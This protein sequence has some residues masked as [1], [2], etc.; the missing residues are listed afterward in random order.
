MEWIH[1]PVDI[2]AELYDVDDVT[3]YWIILLAGLILGLL[4]SP[5]ENRG[6]MIFYTVLFRPRT[7]YD[8]ELIHE[9]DHKLLNACSY[10]GISK[11]KYINVSR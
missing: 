4:A 9:L 1:F 5:A 8:C 7:N 2:C 3:R 11:Q 6:C 10:L